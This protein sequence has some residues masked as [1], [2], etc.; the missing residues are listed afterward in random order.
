MKTCGEERSVFTGASLSCLSEQTA[1][2]STPS[3]RLD[4]PGRSYVFIDNSGSLPSVSL[5]LLAVYRNALLLRRLTKVVFID[6][7]THQEFTKASIDTFYFRN[8]SESLK[9]FD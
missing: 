8:P 7:E 6:P 3:H 5:T 2:R 9:M 4:K 1:P